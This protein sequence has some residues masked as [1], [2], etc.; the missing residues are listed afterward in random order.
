[1][2]DRKIDIEHNWTAEMWDWPLEHHDGITRV[3]N[4]SKRFEVHLSVPYF[5]PKEVDVEV[6]KDQV[7]IFCSHE[8]RSDKWG[9]VKRQAMHPHCT[10]KQ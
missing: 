4:D 1:M 7:V 5:T 3:H 10:Q 9:S 2:P 6:T 8:E